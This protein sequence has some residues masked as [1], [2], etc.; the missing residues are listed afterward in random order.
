LLMRT[1]DQVLSEGPYGTIFAKSVYYY[2]G[3]YT[4]QPSDFHVEAWSNLGSYEHAKEGFVDNLGSLTAISVVRIF[5]APPGY[6]VACATYD[7]SGRLL[8]L[9]VNGAKDGDWVHSNEVLGLYPNLDVATQ[10]LDRPETRKFFGLPGSFPISEYLRHPRDVGERSELT[11]FSDF[12]NLHYQRNRY[13]QQDVFNPEG[14][15]A[16][17]LLIYKATPEDQ[18]LESVDAAIKFGK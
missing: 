11:R 16:S 14:T 13:V 10:Y 9:S 1:K 15:H 3:Q 18:Q 8:V 2:G 6:L 7:A 17:H 12:V 4:G 5:K